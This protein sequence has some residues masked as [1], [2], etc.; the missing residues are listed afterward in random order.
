MLTALKFYG[1]GSCQ[2]DVGNNLHLAIRKSS[3][4][5]FLHQIIDFLNHQDIIR[6]WIKFPRNINEVETLKQRYTKLSF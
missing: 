5:K 4:S 1:G 2:S 6:E 3:V